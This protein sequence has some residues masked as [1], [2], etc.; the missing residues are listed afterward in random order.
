[1]THL[2]WSDKRRQ[3]EPLLYKIECP[4]ELI[5]VKR[6][7]TGHLF[8]A[9]KFLSDKKKLEDGRLEPID[10]I[11]L[12]P[13]VGLVVCVCDPRTSKYWIRPLK[14]NIVFLS[15]PC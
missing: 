5:A 15:V 12:F 9:V 2:A 6:S 11:I 14:L 7:V 4:N 8:P 13:I 1:M 3:T 10:D